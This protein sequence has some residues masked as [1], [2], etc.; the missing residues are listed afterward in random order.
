MISGTLMVV[1]VPASAQVPAS[2]QFLAV[3]AIP[4]GGAW[5]LVEE[6]SAAQTWTTRGCGRRLWRVAPDGSY[7]FESFPAPSPM[8]TLAGDSRDRSLW[9][10]TDVAVLRRDAA[11][12]WTSISVPAATALDGHRA[13]I[14]AIGENRALVL[15]SC[16]DVQDHCTDA[17]QVDAVSRTATATRLMAW[18]TSAVPDGRG[19]AWA[20][21]F[22]SEQQ[23]GLP[24][25]GY[26]HLTASGWESWNNAAER[27]EGAIPRGRTRAIPEV[28][29]TN[30]PGFVGSDGFRMWSV[31][32]NG[33]AT[34]RVEDNSGPFRN[35]REPRALI[36]SGH[37]VFLIDGTSY[38]L[39]E[40][41]DPSPVIRRFVAS[42]GQQLSVERVDVPRWWRA[43]HDKR[44][45]EIRGSATDTTLWLV[46]WDM[47]FWRDRGWHMLAATGASDAPPRALQALV[48][49]PLGVGYTSGKGRGGVAF[50]FRPEV[51]V[52]P[53]GDPPLLGIG[54]FFEAQR[55]QHD[56]RLF[57]GGATVVAYSNPFAAAFS[58]GVDS[59]HA[60]DVSGTQFVVSGFLGF[61]SYL[62]MAPFDLPIGLRLDVRPARGE[63]PQTVTIGLSSDVVVGVS[64]F[65]LAVGHQRD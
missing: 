19:G 56:D 58:L 38:D 15:R 45:P 12:A 17:F 46:T 26:A 63:L 18:V 8:R 49:L 10:V 29:A 51:I 23:H 2:T 30:E 31:D 4:G 7:V 47:L 44:T 25:R 36:S 35:I 1:P 20:R 64:A 3:S 28:L 32:E 9:V 50:G 52:G 54:V 5:L 53:K 55:G 60:G 21:T 39:D 40:H 61:R 43:K 22:M 14:T 16:P 24:I 42:T 13:E 6:C 37:D 11:G 33:G 48:S 41:G 62:D 34:L 27:I 57:G 65:A 59:H